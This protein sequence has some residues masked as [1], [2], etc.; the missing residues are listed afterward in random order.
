MDLIVIQLCMVVIIEDGRC[1]VFILYTFYIKSDIVRISMET[2]YIIINKME[3]G[4]LVYAYNML[5]NISPKTDLWGIPCI[6][7]RERNGSY[8]YH[9]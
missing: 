1:N 8:V 2:D 7:R 6:T 3:C 5:K 9:R 4:C